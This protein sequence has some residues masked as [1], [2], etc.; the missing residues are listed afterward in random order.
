MLLERIFIPL[1]SS[2]EEGSLFLHHT[3]PLFF[4]KYSPPYGWSCVFAA[5]PQKMEP[6]KRSSGTA[7]VVILV[8]LI[9]IAAGLAAYYFLKKRRVHIP[10]E[11]TFENTLYFNS[12]SSPGTSDTKDLMSNIEQ[13][14]HA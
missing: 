2:Y 7:G 10:R 5:D 3:F 8:L 12:R 13:N 4:P 9:V 1:T 6:S 11:D 14:E